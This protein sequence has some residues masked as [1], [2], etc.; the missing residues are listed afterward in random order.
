[1]NPKRLSRKQRN[2]GKHDA[3]LKWQF[4][5]GFNAFKRG[6]IVNPFS[7]D[8]MQSRDKNVGLSHALDV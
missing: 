3:P 8:T 5:Q 7:D 2:L 1:M 4:D 6:K